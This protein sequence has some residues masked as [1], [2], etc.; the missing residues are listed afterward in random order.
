MTQ[1]PRAQDELY[2]SPVETAIDLAQEA[3]GAPLTRRT[4]MSV[5]TTNKEIDFKVRLIAR[6]GDENPNI[7]SCWVSVDDGESYEP[8]YVQEQ[9]S[10][11][12]LYGTG[13]ER[14]LNPGSWRELLMLVLESTARRRECAEEKEVTVNV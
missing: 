9:H 11:L 4:E 8:H 6:Q 10:A 14:I 7:H 5:P 3:L 13:H 1:T 12:N 2:R